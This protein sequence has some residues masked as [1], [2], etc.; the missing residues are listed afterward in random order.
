MKVSYQIIHIMHMKQFDN[1][2]YIYCADRKK[3][4][5]FKKQFA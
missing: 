3:N 4:E 1:H 2:V 5:H